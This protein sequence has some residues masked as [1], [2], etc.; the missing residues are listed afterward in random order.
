MATFHRI[1]QTRWAAT[2]MNGE[3]AR[4]YGGRW[5][6]PGLPAVYL[7]E[8]RALAA[9]EI[10]VHAPREALLLEWSLISVEVPDGLIEHAGDAVLPA[11]W[12]NLPSSPGARRFGENWLRSNRSLAIT[13]PSV[14]LPEERALLL[15]P[16]HVSAMEARTLGMRGF[17][18]D[19]RLVTSAV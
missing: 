18:F 2:A 9:L 15:N 7:A 3:G 10:L 16:S 11:D 17:R 5:N 1:V 12:R 6:P 8:S 13:L 4:L 14:I 19:E